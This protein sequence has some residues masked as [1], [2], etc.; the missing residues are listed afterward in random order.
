ME[1]LEDFFEAAERAV[2]EGEK[3]G[4]EEELELEER[5]GRVGAELEQLC[6]R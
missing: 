3:W 1:E 4:E 2:W 5:C 6:K